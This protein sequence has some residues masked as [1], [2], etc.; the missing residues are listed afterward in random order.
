MG[1]DIILDIGCLAGL[2][3]LLWNIGTRIKRHLDQPN[4]KIELNP[5]WKSKPVKYIDTRI[6]RKFSCLFVRNEGK[7]LARRCIATLKILE[8]P[9]EAKNLDNE[10]TLHWADVD[11]SLKTTEPEPIDIGSEPRRLDVVFTPKHELKIDERSSSAMP[12]KTAIYFRLANSAGLPVDVAPTPPPPSEQPNISGS[13]IPSSG[14]GDII[15]AKIQ[16]TIKAPSKG[17]WI[18]IPIALSVPNEA[19]QAY[20][21]PGDYK[22]EISVKCEKGI[23]DTKIFTIKSPENWN[24]LDIELPN[25][26]A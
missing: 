1:I 15:R 24:E 25:K 18:A 23:G 6:I 11:Y 14:A 22:V 19:N 13:L 10:H 20:L 3:A 16:E 26:E 5:Q 21:P 12:F 17:S 9:T 7:I 2:A 4:L 8:K